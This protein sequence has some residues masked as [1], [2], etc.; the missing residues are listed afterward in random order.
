MLLLGDPG[1]VGLD[2]WHGPQQCSSSHAEAAAHIQNRGR[3]AQVLAQGQSSSHKHTQKL[4]PVDGISRH[5][6]F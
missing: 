1:F 5:S 6:H 4:V 2:A 3:L